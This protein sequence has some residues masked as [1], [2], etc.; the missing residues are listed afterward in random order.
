MIY[1]KTP[2]DILPS[3]F[4]T[5]IFTSTKQETFQ[6]KSL[7]DGNMCVKIDYIRD[8]R[9]DTRFERFAG[10]AYAEDIDFTYTLSRK[11]EL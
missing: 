10:Y 11:G 5:P 2:G 1:G 8:M 7:E 9:F 6:T 4:N 3:G